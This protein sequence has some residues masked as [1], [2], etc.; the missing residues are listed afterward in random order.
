MATV[1]APVD[2][3]P[4]FVVML[5]LA[6]G[7]VVEDAVVEEVVADWKVEFC[8]VPATDD[9]DDVAAFCIVECALKAER[10]LPK[11]GLFVGILLCTK[12]SSKCRLVCVYIS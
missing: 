6:E 3:W 4:A 12:S 7:V 11:N 1:V 10:K 5:R 2:D 9:G 8:V